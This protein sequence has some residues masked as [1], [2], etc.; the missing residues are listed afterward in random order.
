MKVLVLGGAG[1]MAMGGASYLMRYPD[2]S[3]IVLSDI[4]IDKVTKVAEMLN[5]PKIK[6]MELD[7]LDRDMLIATAKEYD[8]VLNCVGPFTKFGVPILEAII[9]AGVNYVDVCDDHDAAEDLLRLDQKAKDA[10]ISALI[11]MGTTPGISNVQARVVYDKLD[12]CDSIKIAW[13][14]TNPPADMIKGTYLEA[15]AEGGLMSDAAWEHLIHV[16]TGRIPIWKEGR[17]DSIEALEHGEWI[18]FDEPLGS[19]ESYYIGHAEP[20]TLAKNLKINDFCACLGSIMPEVMRK[21]RQEARG[22]KDAL[23]PPIATDKKPFRG[24][25]IW[26]DRGV[27]GGQAAIAEGLENGEHVR[28]TARV[29]MGV[30]DSAA[31]N[32]SGQAIGVYMMGKGQITEKGVVAPETCI[33]PQPFFE[34]LARYYSQDAGKTFTIDDVLMI[35]RE[36]LE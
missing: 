32:N 29:Q 4:N 25:D 34:E 36:V 17:W 6:V 23:Y 24:T 18:E 31:Y 13:A 20:I 5:S 22:H 3:E 16:G 1:S 15:A 26:Q 21:L 11:C 28:Y 8:V 9:E 14:I 19:A 2:V 10:G 33:D 35:E 27:W 30:H 7:V 12:S